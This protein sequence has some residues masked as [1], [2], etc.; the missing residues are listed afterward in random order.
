MIRTK[1][2]RVPLSA[3]CMY[4]PVTDRDPVRFSQRIRKLS[5]VLVES[6]VKR[7]TYFLQLGISPMSKTLFSEVLRLMKIFYTIPITTA[8]AEKTF[9][10]LRRLKTHLRTTMSQILYVH[11]DRTDKVVVNIPISFIAENERR[12]KY[13]DSL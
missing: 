6:K 5:N 1:E 13:F 2:T 4:M 8:T 7:V 10:T 3:T 12:R 9:S 11:K